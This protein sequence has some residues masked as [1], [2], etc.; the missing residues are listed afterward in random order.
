M[1]KGARARAL[2]LLR[3]SERLERELCALTARLN[4]FTE[5]LQAEVTAKAK[6]EGNGGHV[7]AD[8]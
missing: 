1:P 8:N 4:V 3:E 5:V 6:A 2:E 7:P